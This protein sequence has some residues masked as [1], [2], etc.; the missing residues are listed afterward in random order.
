VAG[1]AQRARLALGQ[2]FL[3]SSR[4]A[5]ELVRAAGVAPE[6]LVVDIGAGHGA[7]TRALARAGA[8]VVAVERDSRLARE[9]REDQHGGFVVVEADAAT[10]TW[11]REPFAVVANLPFGITTAVVARLLGD[12]RVPLRRADLIVQLGFALKRTTAWP[13]TLQG[14]LWSV[15]YELSIAR[16]I[17]RS[18]FAP[19]PA[20]DAA[21][22]RA[23]RRSRPLVPP[24]EFAHFA[25][26][27]RAG[28]RQATDPPVDRR[29]ALELGV[30]RRAAARDLSAEQWAALFRS[31]HP[32]R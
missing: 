4:L 20:V 2:H 13:S 22:L 11:P 17:D 24:T 21:V 15:S 28:F 14:V 26:F 6:D 8:R 32:S 12:P 29:R 31:V 5:D 16:R 3:R 25:A 10:L 27:V 30:G 9:L 18:A 7:L 23:V 19:P 1:T